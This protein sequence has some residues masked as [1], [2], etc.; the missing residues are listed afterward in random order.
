MNISEQKTFQKESVT[1]QRI[2]TLTF[3]RRKKKKKKSLP[4]GYNLE[5]GETEGWETEEWLGNHSLST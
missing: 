4:L 3:V 2:F 5:H 1:L